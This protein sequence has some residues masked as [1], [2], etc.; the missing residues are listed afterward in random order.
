MYIHTY[1]YTHARARV[2]R[3]DAVFSVDKYVLI[4]EFF[5]KVTSHTW[6]SHITHV[7]MSHHTRELV[8]SHMQ[9]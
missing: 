9:T 3:T 4:F 7:D 5:E 1:T 6:I 2:N 8:M